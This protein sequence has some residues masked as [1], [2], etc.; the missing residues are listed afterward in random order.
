MTEESSKHEPTQEIQRWTE[1]LK[2]KAQSEINSFK[3]SL[4]RDPAM[5][6]EQSDRTFMAA[7]HLK[8]YACIEKALQ[9]VREGTLEISNL[10]S[11]VQKSLE[12]I[13]T[14]EFSWNTSPSRSLMERARTIV[15]LEWSINFDGSLSEAVKALSESKSSS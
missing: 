9:S 2:N 15:A 13:Q 6:M 7:A 1:E 12:T 11:Q 14:R 5:A 8:Q 4:D 3:D 10:H